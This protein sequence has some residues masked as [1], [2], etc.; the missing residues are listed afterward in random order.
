LS[1]TTE[2]NL[3]APALL[4]SAYCPDVHLRLSYYKKLATSKTTDDVDR[5]LEEIVDR[6]GKPPEQTHTLIESHR[7]R[8]ACQPFGIVKVDLGPTQGH[9]T[10][11]PNPPIEAIRIIELIQ[12]N[13][14][15]K[16]V[17]NDKL[18][19]EKALPEPAQRAQL[20]RDIVRQLGQP[21]RAIARLTKA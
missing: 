11:M 2:I 8:V 1:V 20:V 17:G 3:H 19:I 13:K 12:K 5:I 10:F 4:T 7:L 18:K 14:H 15:V 21:T 6:F 16:L 9:I